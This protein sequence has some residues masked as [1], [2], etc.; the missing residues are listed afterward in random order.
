VLVLAVP[1]YGLPEFGRQKLGRSWTQPEGDLFDLEWS[2]GNVRL[3][4]LGWFRQ[5]EHELQSVRV[6]L[7]VR[8]GIAGVSGSFVPFDDFDLGNCYPYS[9]HRR[10]LAAE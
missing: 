1:T 7:V 9:G 2:L 5:G 3:P 4:E 8:F 6:P 10:D